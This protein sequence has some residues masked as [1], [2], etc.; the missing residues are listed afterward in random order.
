MGWP[1]KDPKNY[2]LQVF[3]DENRNVREVKIVD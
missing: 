1:L 3:L 2:G